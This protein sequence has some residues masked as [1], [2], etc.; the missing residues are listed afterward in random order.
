[1]ASQYDILGYLIPLLTWTKILNQDL[2][3]AGV[4]WDEQIQP[5]DH[6]H[7]HTHIPPVA[8][9]P[10]MTCIHSVITLSALLSDLSPCPSKDDQVSI[11]EVLSL[12]QHLYI[13]TLYNHTSTNVNYPFNKRATFLSMETS[14]SCFHFQ[15]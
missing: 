3:K 7:R 8:L 4:G 9:Y 10:S 5:T 14:L 1:M 6:R 13:S 11:P 15:F 2:W 12:A